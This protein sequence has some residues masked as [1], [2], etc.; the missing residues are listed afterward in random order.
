MTPPAGWRHG[1]VEARLAAS[2]GTFV[3]SRDLGVVFGS[4]T[5]YELPSGDTLEPDLSFV[6]SERWRALPRPIPEGFLRIAP[7][8]VV[9][10]LSRSSASRDRHEKRA[11]YAQSGVEEYWLVDTARRQISVLVR[12]GTDFDRG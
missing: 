5:G 12:E 4:S 2:V 6:S 9:E 7:T 10:I 11:I 3:Q 8:L 1:G